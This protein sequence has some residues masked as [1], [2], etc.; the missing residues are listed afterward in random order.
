M[1]NTKQDE[2][3][4]QCVCRLEA[5]FGKVFEHLD[6]LAEQVVT[7]WDALTA[8][9]NKPTIKDLGF[10]QATI[11]ERLADNDTY[12]HG[13][14]VVVEP[15]ELADQ[16]LFLEWYYRTANGKIAPMVLNFNHQSETFYNY[17]SMAWFTRPKLTGRA[18]VEG[19]FVDLY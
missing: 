3:I 14:G 9:G 19:P 16:E 8:E 7:V 5:I 13:T 12:I 4:R 18:S 10:L 17:Q 6:A 11:K 1:L 15:D 2:E